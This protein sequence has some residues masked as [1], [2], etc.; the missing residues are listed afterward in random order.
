MEDINKSKVHSLPTFSGQGICAHQKTP[1]R[2]LS[3][4]LLLLLIGSFAIF[5]CLAAEEDWGLDDEAQ[6]VSRRIQD[7]NDDDDDD[8]DNDDDDDIFA[9]E[10]DNF[11]NIDELLERELARNV[12]K[13]QWGWVRRVIRKI[14]RL[15]RKHGRRACNKAKKFCYLIRHF[16]KGRGVC[17]KVKNVC[18]YVIKKLIKCVR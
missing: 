16:R 6:E 7:V 14:I 18:K 10:E 4:K 8:D 3:S 5:S 17:N 13:G 11:G 2:M 15:L 12:A 1:A 9:M